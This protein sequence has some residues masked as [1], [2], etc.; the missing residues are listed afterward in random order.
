MSSWD[1]G[2]AIDLLWNYLVYDMRAHPDDIAELKVI[3][4]RIRASSNL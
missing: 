1:V 3:G 2:R 4:A